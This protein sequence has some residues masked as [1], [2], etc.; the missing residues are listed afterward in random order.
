MPFNV[1]NRKKVL[2]GC[3]YTASANLYYSLNEYHVF[4]EIQKAQSVFPS[5]SH[6]GLGVLLEFSA[7]LAHAT[8]KALTKQC[9]QNSKYPENTFN[10]CLATSKCKQ[11]IVLRSNFHSHI[12][13]M[14]SPV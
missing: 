5:S 2:K 13:S 14:N 1:A 4:E 7:V 10:S 9:N 11:L 3:N 12:S 8:Q 6:G